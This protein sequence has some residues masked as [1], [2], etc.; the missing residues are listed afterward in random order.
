MTNKPFGFIAHDLLTNFDFQS[1]KLLNLKVS[2]FC[3][4]GFLYNYYEGK[5][6]DMCEPDPETKIY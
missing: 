1:I 5:Q 3:V 2:Q 6:I 4:F